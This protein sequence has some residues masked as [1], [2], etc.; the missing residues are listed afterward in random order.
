MGN[1]KDIVL[2]EHYWYTKIIRSDIMISSSNNQEKKKERVLEVVKY[3]IQNGGPDIKTISEAL[4]ISKSTV[5]RY[6]ND[7]M[8]DEIAIELNIPN[9]SSIIRKFL[10]SNREIGNHMG[11]IKYTSNNIATKGELGRFSGSRRK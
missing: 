5:H 6:L 4:N 3:F 10:D 7:P 1:S 8:I 2:Y 11:G 9:L